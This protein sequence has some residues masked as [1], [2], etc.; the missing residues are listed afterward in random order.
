VRSVS[1]LPG[2]ASGS[3][4]GDTGQV[5]IGPVTSGAVATE[6]VEAV[7]TGAVAPGAAEQDTRPISANNAPTTGRATQRP[8]SPRSLLL[9]DGAGMDMASLLGPP[10]EDAAPL[11]RRGLIAAITF[12]CFVAAVN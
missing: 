9:I 3:G 12:D 6:A 10:V 5:E 11:R 1:V 2:V 7:E 8:R 4:S